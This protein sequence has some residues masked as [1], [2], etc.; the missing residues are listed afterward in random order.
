M[1][2]VSSVV[3]SFASSIVLPVSVVVVAASVSGCPGI[4]GLFCDFETDENCIDTSRA[5]LRGRVVVPEAAG[6][7][8]ASAGDGRAATERPDLAALPSSL[9]LQAIA[10]QML[11]ASPS[12]VNS[13]DPAT[14]RR[15][16]RPATWQPSPTKPVERWRAGEVIV[17]AHEPMRGRKAE[18][19]R[20]LEI[21]LDDR[22]DVDVRLC[23]TEYRCLADIV[24]ADGKPIDEATTARV[25][26]ALSTMPLL[27]FA[28][29]NL[30]LDKASVFPSDEFYTFQW[31]YAAIDVPSA[32]DI[33]TGSPDVVAA[34][35]DTGLLFEHP[36][37]TS[38][39]VGGA[40]LI[41]SDVISN[42]GD[43]RD[44]DGNDVGDNAC[45]TGCHSHHGSHCAGTMAA[46]SNNGL[47]VSGISW[48][49][50]LLAVRVLGEGGGSLNDIADGIEWAIGNDVDGVTQNARPADVINMSL[51]GTGRSAAMAESV[52]NAVSRGAIVVVAA[53]NEDTDASRSTPANVP[54]A[55]TVA[56]LGYNAGSTPARAS[57]SNYGESVDVAAP[58]G[59][60]REDSDGDG[61]GDGV[62]STVGDFV[63][64]SQGTSMAAPHV[65]GVAM[66]MKA[67]SP[68]LTQDEVAA[69][70][71][72]TADV[73]ID[74]E[75][76]CGA[77]QINAFGAVLAASGEETD[78]LSLANVRVGRG[79]RT[80]T[81]VVRN[82]GAD[83]T[84]VTLTVGGSDRGQVSLDRTTATVPGKSML[85]VTA[86]LTR[87]DDAADTGSA[88]I[89][90]TAGSQTA[91]G[92]LDWTGDVGAVIQEVRVMP[93]R[94]DGDAFR[95]VIERLYTT[96]RLRNFDYSLFNL[97][98]GTYLVIAVLDGN[99]D[100]DFDDSED[101]IGLLTRP[102]EEGEVC[103]GGRCNRFQLSAL[104]LLE[105]QDIFLAPG[106][107]GGDD[108]GGNGD[109][110]IG[111]ACAD[112]GDCGSGLYCESSFSG[113]Y[114]T[115]NC[116]DVASD[117]PAGSTCF[118][119]GE[120]TQICF[121]D[122]AADDD[123]VRDGYRCDFIDGVGSCIPG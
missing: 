112:N 67:Q 119:V 56:A 113:G 81:V 54:E 11:D 32:W 71:Q 41:D 118:V 88:V 102:A 17:R 59:E 10:Q 101:A 4:V 40:D 62:L 123:C 99:S 23:G 28:E 90:A 87:S 100:G 78:G 86:T 18:L 15:A 57:Y 24:S 93:I 84:E 79:V 8:S 29:K 121:E 66:L 9:D 96:T 117:C 25:A 109:G 91:E 14:R 106:F 107:T 103:Q 3:R 64:F 75:P 51:G 47:M 70:L 104:D 6:A 74:C 13:L 22:Y 36:D 114:C 45:G 60:Q 39:I 2:P 73:D 50:G 38:R 76:G 94:I 68:A 116:V 69:I 19:A 98:P 7:A 72:A 105:G 82:F 12:S 89:R 108:V 85:S 46:A 44:D 48:E 37:L 61:N 27:K 55:I 30:M 35:I 97:D 33:T 58:G 52:Q 65:A 21:F 83:A 20:A 111:D 63:A 115:A 34:V 26:D 53:G 42:D 43:G 92:R 16:L 1:K 49:G 77:G 31:H 80:A 5:T 120:A 95:P 110:A 122:C